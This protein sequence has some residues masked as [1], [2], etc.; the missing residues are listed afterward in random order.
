MAALEGY[1][2][3]DAS[4]RALGQHWRHMA[5]LAVKRTA[6]QASAAA[7]ASL[8]EDLLHERLLRQAQ[9][10]R[11]LQL[12]QKQVCERMSRSRCRGER[13][14]CDRMARSAC[15]GGCT[16][17]TRQDRQALKRHTVP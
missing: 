1:R 12:L 6:S 17:G 9:V 15:E 16:S 4:T 11:R 3:S 10:W 5:H 13:C 7:A 14:V 2:G 8:L